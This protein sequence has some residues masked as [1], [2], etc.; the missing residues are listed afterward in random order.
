MELAL[1]EEARIPNKQKLSFHMFF[2]L[3]DKKY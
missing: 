2:L 1:Y 3:P